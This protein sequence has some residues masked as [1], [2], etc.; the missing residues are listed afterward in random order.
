MLL[1]T[2]ELV[3]IMQIVGCTTAYLYARLVNT[4]GRC[5]SVLDAELRVLLK[6]WKRCR[7]FRKSMAST[8]QTNLL[9]N[10][11]TS[12]DG[13]LSLVLPSNGVSGSA[14]SAV[15]ERRRI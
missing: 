1:K 12:K 15:S 2:V 9:D 14:V 8:W 10:R 11:Y 3:M 5:L 13:Q 4:Q 7:T 6:P